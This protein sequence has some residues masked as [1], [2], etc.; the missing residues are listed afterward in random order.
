MRPR[1]KWH[2]IPSARQGRLTSTEI[3]LAAVISVGLKG[4][5][6]IMAVDKDSGRPAP[7]A[8][9]LSIALEMAME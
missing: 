3:K 8:A 9:P 5:A 6:T 1:F 2:R 7:N 4:I